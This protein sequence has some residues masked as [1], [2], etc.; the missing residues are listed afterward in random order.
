MIVDVGPFLMPKYANIRTIP[1]NNKIEEVVQ[2]W[3]LSL[4]LWWEAAS[5]F[6]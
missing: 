3:L 1:V 2:C 4:D 5:A 6:F